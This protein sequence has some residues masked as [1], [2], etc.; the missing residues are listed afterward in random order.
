M[1]FEAHAPHRY[2]AASDVPVRFTMVVVQPGAIRTE[3][4]A[5]AGRGLLQASGDGA[6]AD[7]AK[8]MASYLLADA[9]GVAS[10]P[11]VIADAVGKAATARR[12]RTRYAVGSGARVVLTARRL[13]PDRGFDRFMN[14]ALRALAGLAV[15]RES[16]RARSSS[17]A[18]TT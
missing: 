3:W 17:A 16:R 5:I 14:T 8:M 6:Y 11:S 4:S 15:R 7:Q 18:R 1:L 13:L 12:P 2:A 10:S 9:E